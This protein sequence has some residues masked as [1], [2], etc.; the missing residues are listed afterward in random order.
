MVFP[1]FYAKKRKIENISNFRG[2][3]RAMLKF[4]GH[5]TQNIFEHLDKRAFLDAK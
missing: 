2:N 3:H 1:F 5:I 4:V